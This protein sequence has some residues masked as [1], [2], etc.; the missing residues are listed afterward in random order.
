M[1]NFRTPDDFRKGPENDLRVENFAPGKYKLTIQFAKP[2]TADTI[3][4]F[5]ND[6]V[7]E[8]KYSADGKFL[9]TTKAFT[10]GKMDLIKQ[11]FRFKRGKYTTFQLEFSVPAGKNFLCA[12][13]EIW[14]KDKA[15]IEPESLLH[16][17]HSVQ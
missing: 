5:V 12:E 17:C 3:A 7:P 14:K 4:L 15:D 13:P 10:T 8:I 1:D 11:D 2:V 9:G 6:S 16:I